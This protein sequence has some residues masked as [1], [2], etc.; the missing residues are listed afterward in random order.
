V[1]S[2]SE[3]D[4][5]CFSR[6]FAVRLMGCELMENLLQE[7]GMILGGPCSGKD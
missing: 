1:R 4:I 6:G 7:L 3:A 2:I 5:N